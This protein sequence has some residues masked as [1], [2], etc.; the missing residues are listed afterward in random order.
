MT[1]AE[2]F[3]IAN[4]IALLSWLA[5]AVA[6]FVPPLR[7]WVDPAAGYVVPALFAVLYIWLI[8]PGALDVLK[9]NSFGSLAGVGGLFARSEALLA[10]WLHFLAFDLFVG[11]WVAR[12]SAALKI[13]PLIV[14]PILALTFMFGP[15]G[16]LAFAL[17]RLAFRRTAQ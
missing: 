6:R 17:V 13:N 10:G 9:D 14:V 16:Y 8:G 15:A 3:K 4:L 2:L 5:L 1:P 11:G 7:R 12:E